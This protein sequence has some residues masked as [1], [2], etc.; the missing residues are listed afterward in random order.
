VQS[1]NVVIL[2]FLAQVC[3]RQRTNIIAPCTTIVTIT[4]YFLIFFCFNF[5]GEVPFIF[6]TAAA[7][8][9]AA[10]SIISIDLYRG[11][12]LDRE[13]TVEEVLSPKWKTLLRKISDAPLFLAFSLNVEPDVAVPVWT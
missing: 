11:E 1:L 3:C 4:L 8:F 9:A 6:F 12:L 10:P 5:C 13:M 7:A 2:R